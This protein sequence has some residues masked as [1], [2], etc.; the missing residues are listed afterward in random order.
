[1]KTSEIRDKNDDELVKLE[2][3]FR[4]QLIKLRVAKSTQRMRNT[5]QLER[6]RKEIARVKTISHERKLGITCK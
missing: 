1:M 2:L 4:D 5:S 6:L 3:E